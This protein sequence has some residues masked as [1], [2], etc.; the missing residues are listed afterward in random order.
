MTPVPRRLLQH[1]YVHDSPQARFQTPTPQ[2]EIST[3]RRWRN[4][5]LHPASSLRWQLRRLIAPVWYATICATQLD[6]LLLSPLQQTRQGPPMMRQDFSQA[7]RDSAFK[8]NA[9]WLSQHK[10][11][12][13]TLVLAAE[14]L[15]KAALVYYCE[16]CLFCHTDRGYFDV[17]HLVPDRSFRVWG[18]HIDARHAINM[19]ILCKSQATGDYGC[20]QCKGAK[21]LVPR[22]RGLAYTHSEMDLNCTP[23]S[24]RP[25]ELL[26]LTHSTSRCRR[27][28][29]P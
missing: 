29:W 7:Q 13:I 12:G 10:V 15:R 20:N 24:E 17:D 26:P 5:A 22:S 11:D 8:A 9:E 25:W 2:P 28:A 14:P 27:L 18:K 23:L 4:V 1:S 16:N 21:S 6:S 3:T 19:L